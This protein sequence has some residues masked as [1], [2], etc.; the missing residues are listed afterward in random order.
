MPSRPASAAPAGRKALDTRPGANG[1]LLSR[2]EGIKAAI[3]AAQGLHENRGANMW[4]AVNYLLDRDEQHPHMIGDLRLALNAIGHH[5]GV[6]PRLK[7]ETA[8]A[9]A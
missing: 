1:P 4:A 8:M 2:W 6:I 9:G 3:Y 7:R 5:L